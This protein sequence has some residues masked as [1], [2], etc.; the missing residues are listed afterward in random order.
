[1]IFTPDKKYLYDV[2]Y[3]RLTV[4]NFAA[5][6]SYKIPLNVVSYDSKDETGAIINDYTQNTERTSVSP[7]GKF[8]LKSG[9]EIVTLYDIENGKE[10]QKLFDPEKA[11]FSRK[12]GRLKNGNVG[13]TFWSNDG[14]FTYAK[15]WN[16]KTISF[17]K[18]AN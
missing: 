6:I 8:I 15:S 13:E 3:G 4:W 14:K 17:W 10:I 2:D 5:N 18:T 7:D 12:T 16:S 1:M 11:D 9:N